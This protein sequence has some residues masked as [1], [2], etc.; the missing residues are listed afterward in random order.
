ME[1]RYAASTAVLI[2]LIG[3]YG[4]VIMQPLAS[5]VLIAVILGVLFT[6]RFFD[7]TR[8]SLDRIEQRLDALE[9]K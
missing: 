7:A 2:A 8:H 5:L 1:T 3:A 6:V 9:K 4:L